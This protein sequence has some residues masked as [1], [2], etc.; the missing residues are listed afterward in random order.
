MKTAYYITDK[1]YFTK[2]NK[3]TAEYQG[4]SNSATWAFNLYL[5]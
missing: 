4:W 1:E 3:G 2:K 5:L